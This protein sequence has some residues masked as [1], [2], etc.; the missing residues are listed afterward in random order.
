MVKDDNHIHTPESSPWRIRVN[1]VETATATGP[2]GL[3]ALFQPFQLSRNSL[4]RVGSCSQRERETKANVG[5]WPPWR[6]LTF[7][8]GYCTA[9]LSDGPGR[10]GL[11]EI[12]ETM[13]VFSFYIFDR[14]SMSTPPQTTPS[15]CD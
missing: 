3:N 7:T 4:Q 1:M 15:L 11:V 8:F 9:F 12:E 2:Q 13:S 5:P 6:A 10:H 14:H